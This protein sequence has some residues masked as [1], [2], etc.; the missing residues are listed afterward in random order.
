MFL[1]FCLYLSAASVSTKITQLRQLTDIADRQNIDPG[2]S[3]YK[4]MSHVLEGTLET[5]L[6]RGLLRVKC[7][8]WRDGPWIFLGKSTLNVHVFQVILHK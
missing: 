6:G 3:S 5:H 2:F 1:C 8:G 4:G 7:G